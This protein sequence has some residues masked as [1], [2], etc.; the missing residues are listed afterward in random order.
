MNA[1]FLHLASPGS[2]GAAAVIAGD[3]DALLRLRA[4]IDTALSGG[5][6]AAQFYSSDGESY[7]MVLMREP[8]MG[9]ACTTYRNEEAPQRSLRET[10]QLDQL[11]NFAL[12]LRLLRHSG[13]VEGNPVPQP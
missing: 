1:Y 7:G 2:D 9:N 4:A 13:P 8:D 11:E 12:A 10:H 5:A 3:N 6:G